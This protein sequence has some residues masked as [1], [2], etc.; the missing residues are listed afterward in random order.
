MAGRTPHDAFQNFIQ[1]L[2]RSLSC[3]TGT[4][5]FVREGGYHPRDE[6]YALT[7]GAPVRI[8]GPHGTHFGLSVDQQYRLVEYEGPRGPWKV[9][10][11]AYE[12]ALLTDV[13]GDEIVAYHWHPRG[14][15]PITTP[16]L[17]VAAG[18]GVARRDVRD[19]HLP[20]GR[21]ALE[22]ALIR[23]IQ[24]ESLIRSTQRKPMITKADCMRVADWAHTY[25]VDRHRR[26]IDKDKKKTRP[27]NVQKWVHLAGGRLWAAVSGV[28]PPKMDG[29]TMLFRRAHEQRVLGLSPR[30][31]GRPPGA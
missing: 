19:A 7:I 11:I 26:Q 10:T 30:Q 25:L 24:R 21:I 18:A 28:Q 31:V 6:P 5:L 17:H 20:T 27:A 29:S 14:R 3:V 12:Y 23:L 4:V 8:G 2:Q 16:H 15:S 22:G 13:D 9:S 1:P